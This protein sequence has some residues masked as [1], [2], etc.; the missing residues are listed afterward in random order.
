MHDFFHA[1]YILCKLYNLTK[2]DT[3]K[4]G[5]FK[6]LESIDDLRAI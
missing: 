6:E 2:L 4:D 1:K 5:L 3:Y